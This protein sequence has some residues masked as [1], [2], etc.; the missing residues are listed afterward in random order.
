MNLSLHNRQQKLI[1]VHHV[2]EVME[3]ALVII[4][5][6]TIPH[7]GLLVQSHVSQAIFTNSLFNENLLASHGSSSTAKHAPKTSKYKDFS[8]KPTVHI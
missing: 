5:L 8:G 3:T 6:I 4:D 2:Q 7:L 1:L